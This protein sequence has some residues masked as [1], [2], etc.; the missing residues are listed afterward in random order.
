M[1]SLVPLILA[2]LLMAGDGRFKCWYSG[3]YMRPD[4][5]EHDLSGN[6]FTDGEAEARTE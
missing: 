2:L 5:G 6:S 3:W 1:K 4:T